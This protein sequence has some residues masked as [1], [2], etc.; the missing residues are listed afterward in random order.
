MTPQQEAF[1]K[2]YKERETT[3]RVQRMAEAWQ[4]STTAL[5]EHRTDMSM[6]TEALLL[7]LED[8]YDQGQINT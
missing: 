3:A 2:Q 7:L 5:P 1:C 6:F 8:L 4:Q